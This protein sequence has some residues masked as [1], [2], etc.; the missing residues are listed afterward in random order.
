MPVPGPELFDW[1]TRRGAL[2]RLVPPWESVRIAEPYVGMEEGQRVTLLVKVGP[3]TLRWISRAS[4]IIPGCQFRDEQIEGP[5]EQ[6]VHTHS[7]IPVSPD[8]SELEDRVEYAPRFGG[9]GTVVASSLVPRRLARLFRY[10]HD[11]LRAD[12]AQLAQYGAGGPRLRIAVTGA[13]GVLGSAIIPFLLT[14]GHDIVRLVRHPP[15]REDEVQWSVEDGIRDVERLGFVDA[16]LH[17]AGDNI[18]GGRW[19]A[20]RKASIRTSRSLGTRRLAE[21]LARLAA[22][23]R[24]FV[25]ASA[26]GYY[27]AQPGD[28]TEANGPD[29]DFLADVA[30]EWEAGADPVARIGARVVWLRFGLILTPAGGALVPMLY[31]AHAGANG[32]MGRGTQPMSWVSIDDVIGAVYHALMTDALTGPVNVTAPTP[33][34]NRDF[35]RTLGRVLRRPSFMPAP[36]FAL[37]TLLGREMADLLLLTGSRALPARLLASGYRFRHTDLED[38]LRHVLGRQPASGDTNGRAPRGDRER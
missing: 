4:D 16:C 21:S 18:A 2:E 23:P 5:F 12:L 11:T 24:V 37:R 28:V 9:L 10:R 25:S 19:T 8:A 32:P 1:H 31:A 22:P 15:R 36:A 33:V 29:T 35:A 34:S 3:A 30:Q 6:W 14:A 20:A 27:G 17:L 38:A 13:S 26:I 7:M